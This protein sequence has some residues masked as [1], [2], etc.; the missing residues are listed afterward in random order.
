MS[1]DTDTKRI[2]LNLRR[3]ELKMRPSMLFRKHR[4]AFSTEESTQKKVVKL[5]TS[6]PTSPQRQLMSEEPVIVVTPPMK[7]DSPGARSPRNLARARSRT[8]GSI[9]SDLHRKRSRSLVRTLGGMLSTR[10]LLETDSSTESIFAVKSDITMSED[11]TPETYVEKMVEADT[12]TA[13]VQLSSTDTDVMKECL[14]L[15]MDTLN[16][17]AQS[18]DVALREFLFEFELPKETQQLDRVLNAFSC[19]YYACNCELWNNEDQVYF[20]TFSLMLLQT[21]HFNTSNKH[22]MTKEEFIKNSRVSDGSVTDNSFLG[23]ELLEYFYDN[24]TYTKFITQSLLM[25]PQPQPLYLLPKMIFNSNSSLNLEALSTQRTRQRSVSVSS[26]A[27][28]FFQ[29]ASNS[30]DPYVLMATDQLDTLKLPLKPLENFNPFTNN[31]MHAVTNEYLQHVT[32][33]LRSGNAIYVRFNKDC[34]WLTGKTEISTSEESE[35]TEMVCV[36]V[37]KIAEIWKEETVSNKFLTMGNYGVKV[38]SKR[39]F[40][41]LTMC[42]LLL[43]ESLAFMNVDDR[44]RV[45]SGEDNKSEPFFITV[46]NDNSLS[47]CLKLPLNGLFA[48]PCPKEEGHAFNVFS[49]NKREMFSCPTLEAMSDWVLAINYVAAIDMCQICYE[50]LNREVVPIRNIKIE[51]KLKKLNAQIPNS[52]AKIDEIL[53]LQKHVQL[54]TPFSPKTRENLMAYFQ[55]LNIRL[56]WLWYE[57]ERNQV[58]MNLLLYEGEACS[59]VLECSTEESL[60]EDSFL[61]EGIDKLILYDYI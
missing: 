53:K 43:F 28:Q 50:P 42:G 7:G 37:L 4:R 51:D 52:R 21:D 38:V 2:P 20:L 10:K 15:Y 12:P 58:Y 54:A 29:T 27:S 55:S 31:S 11:D 61:S 5:P 8:V 36:R 35:P 3:L 24:I 40:G 59:K 44:E 60:L 41:I 26:T 13:L 18:L 45:L 1:T 48:C 57:I 14:K 25:Q 23:K 56:E 17:E 34:N 33:T 16:F 49:K 30:S 47:R 19:R 39:Y 9:E 6:T 22:K 46:D 32:N